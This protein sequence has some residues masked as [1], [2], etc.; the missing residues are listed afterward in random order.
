MMM[1]MMMMLL[2]MMMM[3]MM[4]MMMLLLFIF[5]V[6]CGPGAFDDLHHIGGGD[7]TAF[8]D[9]SGTPCGFHLNQHT[10][11]RRFC[12][13]T[14]QSPAARQECKAKCLQDPCQCKGTTQ[15]QGSRGFARRDRR[16]VAFS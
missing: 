10:D 15:N 3:M 8:R 2:L 13:S 5:P 7:G 1:M 9:L 11:A 16:A 12:F 4:M 14:G 6:A